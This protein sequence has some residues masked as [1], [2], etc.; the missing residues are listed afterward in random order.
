MTSNYVRGDIA[1][2]G[3]IAPNNTGL[4]GDVFVIGC[5]YD[6]KLFIMLRARNN[7][8]C[9]SPNGVG[10][11][12][13]TYFTMRNEYAFHESGVTAYI[14]LMNSGSIPDVDDMSANWACDFFKWRYFG[15]SSQS[16]G[17]VI[18]DIYSNPTGTQ[19]AQISDSN[20]N[21]IRT[22]T[23]TL[24]VKNASLDLCDVVKSGADYKSS[25]KFWQPHFSVKDN[26]VIFDNTTVYYPGCEDRTNVSRF[27]P[28]DNFPYTGSCS[29]NQTNGRTYSNTPTTNRPPGLGKFIN[30]QT[31]LYAGVTYSLGIRDDA[32][33]QGAAV[34][35]EDNDQSKAENSATVTRTFSQ[36][37]YY[38]ATTTVTGVPAYNGLPNG[39]EIVLTQGDRV[40]QS[41]RFMKYQAKNMYCGAGDTA[42]NTVSSGEYTGMKFILI[43]V[44]FFNTN[45]CSERI[46]NLVFSYCSTAEN[47]GKTNLDYYKVNCGA[48]AIKG[49]TS[50]TQCDANNGNGPYFYP[51]YCWDVS[52]NI[53]N[54]PCGNTYAQ[55]ITNVSGCATIDTD[56]SYR[57]I[58][59]VSFPTTAASYNPN[60][61][62]CC[63]RAPIIGAPSIPADPASC[64]SYTECDADGLPAGCYWTDPSGTPICKG[65]ETDPAGCV[66]QC[67]AGRTNAANCE[68]IECDDNGN[69]PGC[70]YACLPGQDPTEDDCYYWY[71][72]DSVNKPNWVCN[73]EVS[74]SFPPGCYD[75]SK[76]LLVCDDNGDPPGC[77]RACGT[78]ENPDD[79]DCNYYIN[80]T[81]FC[82]STGQGPPGC[83][84]MCSIGA[85]SF[86]PSGCVPVYCAQNNVE[87]CIST[88]ETGD[89]P[90]LNNCI[91]TSD[92]KNICI[93]NQTNY[94]VGCSTLC[95]DG[96]TGPSGGVPT[97]CIRFTC[98]NDGNDIDG[99][100]PVD[101]NPVECTADS[102]PAGC[103]WK[104]GDEWICT[105]VNNPIGCVYQCVN[106][107]VPSWAKGIA[108]SCV[109][110]DC[111]E[112]STT[113]PPG[114]TSGG[115]NGG[116]GGDDTGDSSGW[117]FTIAIIVIVI[118]SL[119]VVG[120][121]IYLFTR[122]HKS[123]DTPSK[124]YSEEN[125]VHNAPKETHDT[126]AKHA[127]TSDGDVVHVKEYTRKL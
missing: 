77:Y 18:F 47:K 78:G 56:I 63:Y 6:G 120:G 101:T 121:M 4:N 111:L 45:S 38:F 16:S 125:E 65:I 116:G 7:I 83:K 31:K 33:T 39:A 8:A 84:R 27:H 75:T 34:D 110:V 28:G 67:V 37:T 43:P 71:S 52:G 53:L 95:T 124:G 44:M 89:D 108:S 68:T 87:G 118:V 30:S 127:S 35:P 122:H 70:I 51:S 57:S 88:C 97:G 123:S 81:W 76:T 61:E 72:G 20:G 62:P 64:V 26:E 25:K 96:G 3:E 91:Y 69:P 9:K 59:D 58:F 106:G 82:D 2:S 79:D 22:P 23:V 36:P 13:G 42:I 1:V 19:T 12:N 5:V 113:M 24:T 49:F 14:K 92:G 85:S 126:E 55:G 102:Q 50:D 32:Y 86:T 94:P 10:C 74:T 104:T 21:I 60:T 40:N 93:N 114:C 73:T 117:L 80:G 54:A 112:G 100:Y 105:S 115:D 15:G 17:S 46:Y 107:E 66:Q 98:N 99:C 103:V 90:V 41:Y 109:V 29:H 119:L 11:H 48:N